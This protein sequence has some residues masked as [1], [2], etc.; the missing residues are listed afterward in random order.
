MKATGTERATRRA[1]VGTGRV[2]TR[3]GRSR[4]VM[5]WGG[6]LAGVT[7]LVAGGSSRDRFPFLSAETS[8]AQAAPAP[9]VP[10]SLSQAVRV[11]EARTGGR[12]RKVEMEREREHD[13]YEIKTVSKKQSASVLVGTTSGDVVRVNTQGFLSG[14]FDR[15]DQQEDL[16]ELARLEATSMTLAAAIEKAEQ[17]TGGRAIEAALRNQ[18]GSTLFEV[19]VVKDWNKQEVWVDPAKAEVIT[20]PAPK[21]DHDD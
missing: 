18:Y 8:L 14:V 11:A 6:L 15:D 20:P 10:F 19:W 9:Q 12:A 3:A 21:E 1:L 2:L 13:V 4:R 17:A 5:F 7:A 16:A